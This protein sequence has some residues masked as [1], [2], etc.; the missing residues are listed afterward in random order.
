[1]KV[2]HTFSKGSF[3]FCG[4]FFFSEHQSLGI[5][6]SSFPVSGVL[7]IKT[8]KEAVALSQELVNQLGSLASIY[9]TAYS[10]KRGAA[11]QRERVCVQPHERGITRFLEES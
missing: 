5:P 6:P 7:T 2:H 11:G 1:M 4:N 10:Q 3:M 9:C 8:T